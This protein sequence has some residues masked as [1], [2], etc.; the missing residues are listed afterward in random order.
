[1]RTVDEVLDLFHQRAQF[2]QPIHAQ[3]QAVSAIYGD[4]A[5]VPLPDMD[6]T[7]K[8][9][10]PNLLAQGVDQ[11]AGRI[12]SVVPGVAFASLKP[13]QRKADR[14]AV[15]A[16]RAITGWWERERL[17]M[18]MKRRARHLI[19]YS[20]SPVQMRWD[21]ELGQPIR[22]LRS[23]LE[24][25][26]STDMLDGE[27]IPVDC[28]F[29]YRRS[30]GWLCQHGYEGH[31]RMLFGP[32]A[33]LR[34]DTSI[35]LIEYVDAESTM[36]I[37]AGFTED[38]SPYTAYTSNG[39]RGIVLEHYENV[40]GECSVSVPMRMT[41]DT[42]TGQFDT[43]IGMYQM[44]ARLMALEQIAVEKGIFP[45]TFLESFA[46]ETAT[47]V[48]GPYD[49]RTGKVSIVKGG[50][51]K[52]IQSQPGY[53]TNPTI[54]RLERSQ[55]LTA[56]IPPELGGESSSNIRTGRRGD[57][58]LSAVID[59]PVAEAQEA[60]AY[61]LQAENK[62]GI[63]MAKRYHGSESKTIYV[64]T[65]NARSPV[66]YTPD[67]TFGTE[68]HTVSFPVTG[69][70]LNSFIIGLGQRMGLGMMSAQTAAEMDPY[71]DNAEAERDRIVVEALEQSLLAGMQAQAQSGQMSPMVLSKVM[72]LVGTDKMELA[73]AITKVT[74][75]ALA[76]QQA[77]QQGQQPT[78]EGAAAPNALQAMA[79]GPGG[80]IPG[81][82]VMP[83][84][85]QLGDML[86]QL[87]RPVMAVQDRTARPGSV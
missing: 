27:C 81:M 14:N 41:L 8:P 61:A 62:I 65:G 45:D 25:F 85:G 67:D 55:R 5:P 7:E 24:T 29:A 68:E 40:A 18:K 21:K 78:P 54:D 34:K 13:G 22:Q 49:G 83:G 9:A 63:R 51:I 17:P 19:A 11:M 73:D 84:M 47:F 37:A 36:L 87:R 20:M 69:T 32:H 50:Q 57:A 75:D 43:M 42:A 76:E 53:L 86:G 56:G 30:F 35:L 79:G 46:G 16:G 52:E 66:T 74:E 6:R 1:M 26:P 28:L 77:Q 70:D 39:M 31:L 48:E 59:Y 10:V 82:S 60:L 71:I 3:M 64:G 4:R 58:V 72:R 38:R 33:Q 12:A 2:Y 80:P 44:Q 15:A 23:P